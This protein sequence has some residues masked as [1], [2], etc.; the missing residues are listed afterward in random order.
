MHQWASMSQNDNEDNRMKI[1]TNNKDNKNGKDTKPKST[2]KNTV[3]P[4]NY[5]RCMH[6]TVFCWSL[7]SDFNPYPSGLLHWHRASEVTLNDMG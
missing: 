3:H 1:T 7:L 2:A 6:F 5:T 4:K